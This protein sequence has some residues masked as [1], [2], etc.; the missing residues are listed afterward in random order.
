MPTIFFR[1]AW[2]LFSIDGRVHSL[3]DLLFSAAGHDFTPQPLPPL[4]GTLPKSKGFGEGWGGVAF[5]G[6]AAKYPKGEGGGGANSRQSR[7]G[8]IAQLDL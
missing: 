5:G 6:G 7:R 8:Q 2:G 4:R 3:W 1:Q